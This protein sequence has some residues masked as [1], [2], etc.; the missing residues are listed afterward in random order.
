[1]NIFQI[2]RNQRLNLSPKCHEREQ[3]QPDAFK[4]EKSE[5]QQN[6]LIKSET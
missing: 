6:M 5:G 1:M 4:A 2:G 3:D